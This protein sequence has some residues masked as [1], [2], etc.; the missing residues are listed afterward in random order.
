[1]PYTTEADVWSLGVC[2]ALLLTG[3]HP[4]DGNTPL[5]LK[6]A[7]CKDSINFHEKP[8]SDLSPS[9]CNLVSRMLEKDLAKRITIKEV[10]TADFRSWR[11]CKGA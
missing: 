9:A 6:T 7:I 4:F 2:L 3:T 10:K 5:E 1:M 11:G 8:W